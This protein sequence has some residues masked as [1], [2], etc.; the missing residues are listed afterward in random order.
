MELKQRAYEHNAPIWR[1]I[2]KRLNGPRRLWSQVNVGHIDKTLKEGETAIVPGKVLSS[3]NITK[4]LNV[5]AFSFSKNSTVK[6]ESMGG[7]AILIE[8][9][10]EMNPEG[11]N[12]RI[13]G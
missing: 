3:G 5:V 11:K 2:S 4:K 7:K 12:T 1:D 9:Y 13:L 8:D 6:I 10:L